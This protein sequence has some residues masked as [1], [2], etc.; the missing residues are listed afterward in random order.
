[1]GAT[2]TV[3]V[4]APMIATVKAIAARE[5]GNAAVRKKIRQARLA[6]ELR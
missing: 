3:N 2:R 4:V 6:P 5:Q 1:M